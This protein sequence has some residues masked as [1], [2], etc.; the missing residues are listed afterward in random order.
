MSKMTYEITDT[1]TPTSATTAAASHHHLETT[2]EKV[3]EENTPR[4]MLF[5]RYRRT[6]L[7]MATRFSSRDTPLFALRYTTYTKEYRRT[8]SFHSPDIQK[9]TVSL[10]YVAD[11]AIDNH[12]R[13]NSPYINEAR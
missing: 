1:T 12:L 13:Q 11:L 7:R 2:N 5:I 10:G 9:E 8:K 4:L 6:A 3:R